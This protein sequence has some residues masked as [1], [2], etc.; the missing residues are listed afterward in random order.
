MPDLQSELQPE[1]QPET[2]TIAEIE[3]K[4]KSKTEPEPTL[5]PDNDDY[6]EGIFVSVFALVSVS[7][8]VI[9]PGP[10]LIQFQSRILEGLR[11][12]VC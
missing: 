3:T 6:A 12:I 10:V 5:T 2:E 4:P 9:V 8:V 1:L 7:S 11:S